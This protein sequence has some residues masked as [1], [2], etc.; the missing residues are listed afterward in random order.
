[1][2][3]G[4]YRGVVLTVHPASPTRG[5]LVGEGPWVSQGVLRKAEALIDA[6][7]G[8]HGYQRAEVDDVPSE[9]M[10]SGSLLA[11]YVSPRPEGAYRGSSKGVYLSLFLPDDRSELRISINDWQNVGGGEQLHRL[12]DELRRELEAAFPEANIQVESHNLGSWSP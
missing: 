12:R 7:A 2:S 6:I 5:A 8:S 3:C 9:Y 11:M 10:P 1:M 4:S